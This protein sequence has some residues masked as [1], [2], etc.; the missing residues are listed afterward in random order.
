M[1]RIARIAAGIPHHVTQRENRRLP[2]FFGNED[3]NAYIDLMAVYEKSFL[4]HY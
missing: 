4:A 2:T 1:A 3:Y